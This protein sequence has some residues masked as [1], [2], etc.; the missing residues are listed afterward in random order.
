M[1]SSMPTSVINAPPILSILLFLTTPN[2]NPI[3]QAAPS[4][5]ETS[6]PP[7]TTPTLPTPLGTF[8]VAAPPRYQL[9]ISVSL[10]LLVSIAA[11]GPTF[12][13]DERKEPKYA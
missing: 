5:T 2:Q 6:I 1:V 3:A 11:S 12:E 13:S 4:A 9:P 8:P 10:P 7:H